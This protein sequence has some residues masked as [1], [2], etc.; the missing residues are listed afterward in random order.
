MTRMLSAL[1]LAV[2][3][4][5]AWAQPPAAGEAGAAAA[6]PA[7]PYSGVV[8]ND[9]VTF[10]GQEFY[11]VFVS[12][13]REEP[14]VERFSVTIRERPSARWGSLVS[15]EYLHREVFRAFLSPGR[16]DFV[17]L[18]GRDAAR[19]VY[20]N[21]VDTEVQRLLFRDPDLAQDEL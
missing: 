20:E 13:W 3:V 15:V 10:I 14:N 19:V 4:C 12:H 8:V 5:A 9:T 11:S 21:V 7:D 2:L 6:R 17:R 18:A 1:L 16:R